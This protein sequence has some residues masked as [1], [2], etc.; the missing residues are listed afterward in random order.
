MATNSEPSGY[1]EDETPP[2]NTSPK[3]PIS[4]ALKQVYD[5]VANEPLPDKLNSLLEQLRLGVKK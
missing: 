1:D 2:H 3:D 4:H 5:D